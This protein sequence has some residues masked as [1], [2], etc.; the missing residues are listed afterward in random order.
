M[1]YQSALPMFVSMALRAGSAIY[2]LLLSTIGL[3][4]MAGSFA[5]ARCSDSRYR[6]A[7]FGL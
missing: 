3:G 6:P 2:G 5:V 1:A 7:L 4:A